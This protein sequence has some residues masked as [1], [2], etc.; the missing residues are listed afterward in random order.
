MNRIPPT[1]MI[2]ALKKSHLVLG[3]MIADVTQE[4]A[5]QLRDGAAGWSVLEIVCHVRDYQE[6]LFERVRRMVEEERPALKPY[7]E[8]AREAM[9][10]EG[11]YNQQDMRAVYADFC[12]MRETLIGYLRDLT[13]EQ[14]Q[15]VGTHPM[16][17]EDDVSVE[18]FHIIT[19]DVDHAEQ[20]GRVVAGGG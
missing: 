17:G 9:V 10:I 6:L 16:L 11:Q 4:Q 20:I 1:W 8:T 3:M 18:V 7:D 13:A 2:S 19:H 15:R 12:S 14:W 5:Q